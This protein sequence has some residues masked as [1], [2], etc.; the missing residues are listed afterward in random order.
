M[1]FA[2][3]DYVFIEVLGEKRDLRAEKLFRRA[4]FAFNLGVNTRD[5]EC[6]RQG[7]EWQ[8]EGRAVFWG[9]RRMRWMFYDD[10][11]FASPSELW[12]SA[13]TEEEDEFD[14]STDSFACLPNR[15]P[16]SAVGQKAD[17]VLWWQTETGV[18]EIRAAAAVDFE[19]AAAKWTSCSAEWSNEMTPQVRREKVFQNRARP[20]RRSVALQN[21][22]K[23]K[24]VAILEEEGSDLDS[25]DYDHY[26]YSDDES[27][28]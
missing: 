4:T 20:P 21:K 11:T 12:S 25:D 24:K 27:Y 5:A 28:S 3:G 2:T 14:A 15:G 17:C 1:S 22:N 6:I 16:W 19:G 7:V 18:F 13:R 9:Y 26:D 23:K 8:L 10:L